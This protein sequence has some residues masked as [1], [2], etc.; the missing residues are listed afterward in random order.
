MIKRVL[1]RLVGL[2]TYI[3]PKGFWPSLMEFIIYG[4]KQSLYAAI[5]RNVEHP[6]SILDSHFNFKRAHYLEKTVYCELPKTPEL[7]VSFRALKSYVESRKGRKD[8][9]YH[10]LNQLVLEY[11]NYPNKFLCPMRKVPCERPSSNEAEIV[12][13]VIV[14]RRSIRQFR[15]EPV[16]S[17]VLEK[18]IDA[19]R[20]APNSCNAQAVLFIS[21]R[22]REIIDLIFGGTPG[23][24]DWKSKIPTGV[25]V[26]T[27]RRHYRPFEQHLV[28]VQDIAAATQNILLMA[29]VLGLAA[30]WV[31][32]ISDMVMRNQKQIYQELRLPPHIFVGA[33]I[34]IGYPVS[35]VC[36]VPRRP[37]ENVWFH[38]GFIPQTTSILSESGVESD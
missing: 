9:N 30:C 6:D 29:H 21:T 4:I 19:G 15:E 16:D 20:Y 5:Y 36:S 8:S 14:E 31:T 35:K 34:A 11:E 3:P 26:G 18:I 17:T 22:S 13:K 38:E 25:I 28:M 33:A 7:D 27:D 23:A 12:R 24:C 10:Y 37:L 1:S 2:L 32:L